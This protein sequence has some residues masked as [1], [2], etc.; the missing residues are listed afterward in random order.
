[1]IS[2]HRVPLGAIAK[3]VEYAFSGDEELIDKY[4]HIGNSFEESTADTIAK[5]LQTSTMMPLQ[6]YAINYKEKTIG[7][8]V[9]GKQNKILYSFGIRKEFRIKELL[10]DWF[11]KMVEIMPEFKCYLWNKNSRAINFLVKNGMTKELI[12]EQYTILKYNK[13][14]ISCH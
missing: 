1:M 10:I 5:I 14:E 8:F 11:T 2:L 9:I 7:Y 3:L 13:E 4:H 12:E 6:L